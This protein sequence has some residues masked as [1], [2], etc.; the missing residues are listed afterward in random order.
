MFKQVLLFK[1]SNLF[2]F[3]FTVILVF[4]FLVKI[5]FLLFFMGKSVLRHLQHLSR[6]NLSPFRQA[7]FFRKR[8]IS[9]FNVI[10][11]SFN[12]GMFF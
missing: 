7:T 6:K 10:I 8:F 2:F 1:N 12:Q 11:V 5:L 9:F 3:K 4:V